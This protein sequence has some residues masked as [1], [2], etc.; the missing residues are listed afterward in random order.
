MSFH[1]SL[2][3]RLPTIARDGAKN[4]SYIK[5]HIERAI[6]RSGRLLLYSH[7]LFRFSL[8]M[9]LGSRLYITAKGKGGENRKPGIVRGFKRPG[10]FKE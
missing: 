2:S 3:P 1:F 6:Y 5:I 10:D 4:S 9:P 8:F 7:G